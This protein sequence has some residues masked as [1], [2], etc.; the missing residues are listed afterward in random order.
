[1]NTIYSVILHFIGPLLQNK[2]IISTLNMKYAIYSVI[3]HFY[4][5]YSLNKKMCIILKYELY[6]LFRYFTFYWPYL[7]NKIN[8]STLNMKICHLFCYFEFYWPYRPITN[9]NMK[10]AIYSVI[11]H[12]IG[13]TLQNTKQNNNTIFRYET[14]H[15]FRYFS[16]YRPLIT[17]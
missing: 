17:K 13:L 9:Q 11:L 10:H 2:I 7:Q 16:F 15:L 8:I 12:Y 14:C 6:H 5:H 3:L 4:R 1:M